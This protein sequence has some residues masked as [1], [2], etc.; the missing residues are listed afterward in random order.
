MD[1]QERRDH[2]EELM[3]F[4]QKLA[5]LTA[6]L[7][8][9]RAWKQQPVFFDQTA[10]LVLDISTNGHEP[11]SRDEYRADPLTFL[12]LDFDLSIPANPHQFG[13]TSSIILIAF[14]HAYGQSR[15][16]MPRVDANH[17]KIDPVGCGLLQTLRE[18]LS[19]A[20]A[21]QRR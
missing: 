4:A 7:Q 6:K 17:R 14:V 3:I 1:R 9:D 12:A 16:R 19:S 10:D 21:D 18:V 20:A 13:Q 8:A 2:T 15:V 5:D 11:G